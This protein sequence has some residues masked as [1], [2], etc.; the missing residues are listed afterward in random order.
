MQATAGRQQL[1]PVS[2]M[3]L[4]PDGAFVRLRNRAQQTY[5]HA[6]HDGR[7]FSLNAVW[8][9]HRVEVDGATFVL[10]QGAAYGRYL[11]ISPAEAPPGHHGNRAVQRDYEG[12][13]V[14]ALM[15]RPFRVVDDARYVRLRQDFNRNLR[16][17]GRFRFWHTAVTVDTNEGRWTT[18][19]QWTVGRF[20][21]GPG[22]PP[23]PRPT[24]VSSL[25]FLLGSW[26]PSAP[27]LDSVNG[28]LGSWN[29]FLRGVDFCNN[30]MGRE[31]EEPK[32][33]GKRKEGMGE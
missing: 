15:W 31:G 21:L 18:M 33:E 11:A 27:R 10:L 25:S 13:V 1:P 19:M 22:L 20:Q 17:N 30:W 3:D 14:G 29:G 9:V 12:A 32:R 26:N 6:D 5:L 7:V 28:L 16:A 2:A 4:F 8:R 23:L 24:V